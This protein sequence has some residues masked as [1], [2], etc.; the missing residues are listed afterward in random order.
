M[1][2]ILDSLQKSTDKRDDNK[3]SIDNFNF[4]DNKSNSKKN[5]LVIFAFFAVIIGAYLVYDYWLN[6]QDNEVLTQSKEN[7]L[8]A[9]KSES[10]SEKLNKKERPRNKDVKQNMHQLEQKK[11]K[12]SKIIVLGEPPNKNNSVGDIKNSVASRKTNKNPKTQPKRSE[13]TLQQ[14]KKESNVRHNEIAANPKNSKIKNKGKSKKLKPK[15]PKYEPPKQK[16]LYVYQLPFSIRKD[17]PKFK[18]NIHVYDEKPEN[19]L[20]I[21]NGAKFVI[22]DM[23]D[24]KAL[25]KDIIA[26]GVVLDIDGIEFLIP[27][28]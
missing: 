1:S 3:N 14:D 19:R 10:K 11:N 20:V 8:V 9:K 13:L 22:D 4:S 12:K 2:T 21:I 24:E 27:K 16:Y 28:L 6:S 26:E 7:P 23:I 25:I 17:I 15:R 18:L 5:S